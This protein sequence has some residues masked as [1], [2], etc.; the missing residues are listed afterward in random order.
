[1]RDSCVPKEEECEVEGARQQR[2]ALLLARA[3]STSGAG[4]W[5]SARLQT[6]NEGSLV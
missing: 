4:V 2:K 6:L 5:E 3:E 1:M